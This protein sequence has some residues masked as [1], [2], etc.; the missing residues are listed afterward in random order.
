MGRR[1]HA[2]VGMA[3]GELERMQL[4]KHHQGLA[5]D[6]ASEIFYARAIDMKARA[7]TERCL[8]MEVPP[9]GATL[10]EACQRE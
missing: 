7:A 4:L 5:G 10:A 3:E 9:S 8:G 1:I 6:P 2:A